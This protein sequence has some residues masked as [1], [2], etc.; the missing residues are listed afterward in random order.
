M[1][2]ID[3]KISKETFL[4][5]AFKKSKSES[6]K[7]NAEIALRNL[8]VF[9][10]YAYKKQMDTVLDDLITEDNS[11]KTFAF[12]QK[13]VDFMQEDHLDILFNPP[14]KNAKAK[15]YC[16]KMPSSIKGYV[17]KCR[18]YAKMRGLYIDLEDFLDNVSL[19]VIEEEL[20]PDPFTHDEIRLT[21]TYASPQRKRLYMSLKDSAARIGEL[22]QVRKRDIDFTKDPVEIHLPAKITKGRKARMIYLSRETAP[23]V[24]RH[25]KRLNELDLVYG[26]NPSVR[27]AVENEIAYFDRLRKNMAK[28]NPV[29]AERYEHNGRFKKNIHS[30]KAFA[31][32]QA[33]E[34]HGE[35]YAHGFGAHKKYL[36]QYIRN[37]NK[38]VAK[39]KQLESKLLIFEKIEVV[40]QSEEI[41]RL[42]KQVHELS[43]ERSELKNQFEKL[44]N[45]DI[46][47]RLEKR[48]E[49]LEYGK[50]AR[51]GFYAQS[52]LQA[53]TPLEKVLHTI[54]PP[55]FEWGHDEKYKRKF[56][57]EYKDAVKE[58]RIMNPSAYDPDYV[59]MSDDDKREMREYATRG[60]EELEKQ[61][62]MKK[63]E[64]PQISG[65]LGSK[66]IKYHH[67]R[68]L[69]D[70]LLMSE[71]V[72]I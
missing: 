34:V 64:T 27:K 50:N 6:S 14:F 28:V 13:F 9:C 15:P 57:K 17:S 51:D 46:I 1:S 23:D 56:W 41:D 59:E 22:C 65:K 66:K 70:M 21:C 72:K 18:K 5:R 36:P 8:E 44:P 69:R 10:K 60:L 67:E 2:Y 40:E 3:E 48:I 7:H 16:A 47:Q 31:M 54:F 20:D 53:K 52:T 39:Y 42:T 12:F 24:Q 58:K 61:L 71:P 32:T 26:T 45:I 38:N 63:M 30:L 19:P 29:F 55:V 35:A 37:Q 33:E 62:R 4:D 68:A 11:K 43:K 49:D 25:C